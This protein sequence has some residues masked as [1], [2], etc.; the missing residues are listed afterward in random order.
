[1]VAW[2]DGSGHGRRVVRRPAVAGMFYPGDRI[3]LEHEVDRMLA[4]AGAPAHA[5]GR[6][7]AL[8]E[9]HAGYPYSGR[10]RPPAIASSTP[11][12]SRASSSSVRATMRRS[13]GSPCGTGR[14]SALRSGTCRSTASS[15]TR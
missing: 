6:I 7:V 9:P 4:A 1:M 10:S 3:H 11:P 15:C 13:P 5:G 14:R 2:E 8:V 12:S